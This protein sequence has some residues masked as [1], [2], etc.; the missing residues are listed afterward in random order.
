[1]L[2]SMSAF[3]SARLSGRR[4]ASGDTQP[5][6]AGPVHMF[7][8]G[9][10][11][12]QVDSRADAATRAVAPEAGADGVQLLP[13]RRRHLQDNG[14]ARR[15]GLTQ[16]QRLSF[17]GWRGGACF[18]G[19]RRRGRGWGALKKCGALAQE[20]LCCVRAPTLVQE[21]TSWFFVH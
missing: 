7:L 21:I 19:V 5:R 11:F 9:L 17:G 1:M 12:Y 13:R 18:F 10:S 16:E 2:L 8:A 6:K 15:L 4:R 14:A 3:P 20:N